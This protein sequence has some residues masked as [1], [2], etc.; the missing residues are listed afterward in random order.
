MNARRVLARLGVAALGVVVALAV[1]ELVVRLAVPPS[2]SEVLRGLHVA[3]PDRPWLYGLEPRAR[4][5]DATHPGV[6]YEVNADGFRDRAFVRDPADDAFRLLVLGDSI[7]FGYGVALERTFA[8]QLE[9]RLRAAAPA[10]S[11]EVLN[12]GV[13]GYNPYT[14]AALLEDVGLGYRPDLVL[15][16]FCV[17]DLND[18]TLHFDASTV[19]AL[20]DIPDAAFPDGAARPR[21]EPRAGDA[22]RRACRLSRLC[23][24]LSDRFAPPLDDAAMVRALSP[25]GDPSAAE[26]AWLEDQYERMARAAAS[27]DARLVLVVFPY[28]TQLAPGAPDT[29]QRALLALGERSGVPVI[30]LLPAF[31]RAAAEDDAPLFL[32]LWHPTA[33]GHEVAAETIFQALACR[34]LVPGLEARCAA[35]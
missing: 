34:G 21:P 6:V 17:N 9:H 13:S 4:R 1:L 14:E 35:R 23:T 2:A 16:Q 25:R 19:L 18:P 29:L 3:R 22:L 30:D 5:R 31:R 24:L 11:F 26:V 27:R 32:D 28:E 15:A 12:L 33:R 10:P 7:A 8:K 20:G